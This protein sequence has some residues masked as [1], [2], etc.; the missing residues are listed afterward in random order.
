MIAKEESEQS[1]SLMATAFY[2][3]RRRAPHDKAGTCAHVHVPTG[4]LRAEGCDHHDG[5]HDEDEDSS[6][7]KL[8]SLLDTLARAK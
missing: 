3:M 2:E 5:E 4:T 1:K 8:K 6:G 7:A